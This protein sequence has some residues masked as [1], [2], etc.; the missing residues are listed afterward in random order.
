[1]KR[2]LSPGTS[3]DLDHAVGQLLFRL[4][5]ERDVSQASLGEELGY[6]QAFVSKVEHAQRRVS[7][8]EVLRWAAALGVSYDHLSRRVEELWVEHVETQ[9][10]WEREGRSTMK[11]KGSGRRSG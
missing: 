1:M 10:I 3:N 5:S 7:L 8:S 11:A 9:S 4:R 6:D 2:T